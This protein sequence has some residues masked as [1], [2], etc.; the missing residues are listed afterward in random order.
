VEYCTH[1]ADVR[2]NTKSRSWQQE[3]E[4]AVAAAAVAVGLDKDSTWQVTPVEAEAVAVAEIV[5]V[6]EVRPDV[7][8]SPVGQ[9]ELELVREVAQGDS[10]KL[11]AM[12]PTGA[13][14]EAA[15][16][17]PVARDSAEQFF[18]GPGLE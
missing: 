11:S 14:V 5:A 6:V 1:A 16:E 17:P 7:E 18:A 10:A 4:K 8:L 12:N 2:R 9:P 15:R 3:Y 13:V